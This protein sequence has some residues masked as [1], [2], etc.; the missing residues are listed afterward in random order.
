MTDNK[1]LERED[2][3]VEKA[4]F[5]QVPTSRA[6]DRL[7]RRHRKPHGLFPTIVRNIRKL[8]RG[9]GSR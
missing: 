4:S 9:T 6:A 8:V 5:E 3:S 2:K 1:Q 7:L